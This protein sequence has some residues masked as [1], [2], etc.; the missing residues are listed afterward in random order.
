MFSIGSLISLK[1]ITYQ[2]N[3]TRT[4]LYSTRFHYK[5]S[6]SISAKNEIQTVN[7]K[8]EEG[9]LENAQENCGQKHDVNG[10]ELKVVERLI[11]DADLAR[12]HGRVLYNDNW[13]TFVA[14]ANHLYE[15]YSWTI[16]ETITNT[17][18]I[19]QTIKGA[20]VQVG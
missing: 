10:S 13:Y 20:L 1:L 4:C 9:N 16:V 11:I 14:L 19:S 17:C 18:S 5:R 3:G 15:N 8:I 2:T 7:T 12:Q 6:L